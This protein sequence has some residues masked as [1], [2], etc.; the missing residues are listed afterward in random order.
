MKI[1][2]FL[3]LMFIPFFAAGQESASPIDDAKY[4]IYAGW[5][6]NIHRPSFTALP[7]VP[8]CC[9][10]FEKGD[11]SGFS[12]GFLYELPIPFGFE[13]G[14]R[15]G[16]SSL[17]AKLSRIED[18]FIR[19]GDEAVRGEFEHI[20]DASLAGVAV[21]PYI[22]YNVI[23]GLR[24]HAGGHANFLLTKTYEQSEVI[25]QPS[26][27]GVFYDTGTRTRNQSSGDIPESSSIYAA[28]T[29]G[30][31]YELPLN[32]DNTMRLAPEVHFAL[33]LT[34]FV[35][36]TKWKGDFLRA[37]LAIK[38]APEPA[39]KVEYREELRIDTLEIESKDIRVAEY[40]R[41]REIPMDEIE[42]K[43]GKLIIRNQ[44]LTRTDTIYTPV[45]IKEIVP[46]EVNIAVNTETITIAKKY[47]AESFPLMPLVFFKKNSDKPLDLYDLI[48]NKNEFSLNETQPKPLEFHRKL[49]NIIGQ[50]MFENPDYRITLIGGADSVTE[51]SDCQLALRRVHYIRDYFVNIWDIDTSRIAINVPESKCYPE[52]PTVTRNEIGYSE[53]RRVTIVAN[54]PALLRPIVRTHPVDIATVEPPAIYI[55]PH[56]STVSGVGQWRALALQGVD[57]LLDVRGE[58]APK[59]IEHSISQTDAMELN[60]HQPIDIYYQIADTAGKSAAAY[61]S[62]E[63]VKDTV[64]NEIRRIAFVLFEVRK[65]DI[66]DNHIFAL[67][68]LMGYVES[69]D[70]IRITGYTDNLGNPEINI[71]LAAERARNTAGFIKEIKPDANIIYA[72]GLVFE[73]FPPG[74]DSY[75]T[76]PE[77]FLSR[78]VL[79][80]IIRE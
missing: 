10:L 26:D 74:I 73:E 56:G 23:Y 58:G 76:P 17:G 11:G 70:K 47:T 15:A 72:K 14:L 1:S 12:V 51:R 59:M 34:D 29:A 48:N 49:L 80:E 77:R 54:D 55:D 43:A 66:R 20:I 67:R 22:S 40:V 25:R 71:E 32:A 57:T 52:N 36:Q 2:A 78:T 60:S 28:L 45:M 30:I 39:P 18:E 7:G 24:L 3:L 63:V 69:D 5:Q 6:Y 33:G 50:R 53:N 8:N 27:R 75:D 65:S 4:G 42:E 37:G 9:P 13:V 35:R 46:L 38:Y 19:V 41:G 16:Y 64:S 61:Q 62:I 68:N 21:E 79:I 44:I 31:S